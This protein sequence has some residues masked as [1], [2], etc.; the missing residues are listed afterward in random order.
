[1]FLTFFKLY[2]NGITSRKVSQ[3]I[4][5]HDNHYHYKLLSWWLNYHLGILFFSLSNI[6]TIFCFRPFHFYASTGCTEK[7]CTRKSH[8]ELRKNVVADLD[9]TH[10]YFFWWLS[11]FT[12]TL[13]LCFLDRSAAQTGNSRCHLA[14]FRSKFFSGA[15]G[16]IRPSKLHPKIFKKNVLNVLFSTKY[17]WEFIS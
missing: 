15:G 1:M 16:Y 6:Y 2:I 14:E 17:F 9:L 8:I 5:H 10:L 3:L 13:I 7:N 11:G 4:H 12:L